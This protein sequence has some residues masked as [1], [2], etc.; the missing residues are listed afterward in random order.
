M[1][2]KYF[3]YL[4]IFTEEELKTIHKIKK[5]KEEISNKTILAERF[6]KYKN[7]NNLSFKKC[8]LLI[9][10]QD[11][12]LKNLYRFRID[13]SNTKIKHTTLNKPLKESKYKYKIIN[14]FL[15]NNNY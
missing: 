3:N 4:K 15:E 11:S 2:N 13:I 6:I 14:E 9:G 10:I 1:K 5:R 8:S 12:F 7:D